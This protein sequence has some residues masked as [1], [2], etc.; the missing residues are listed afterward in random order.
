MMTIA[1]VE[2][3][4]VESLR[5]EADALR[6]ELARLEAA[7]TAAREGV[8]RA[9]ANRAAIEGR[10]AATSAALD[11]LAAEL[12]AVRGAAVAGEDRR[13][14]LAELNGRRR[15]LEA[16]RDELAEQ[17]AVARRAAETAAGA[18]N[19]AIRAKAGVEHR[20]AA[21]EG[22]IAAGE[23]DAELDAALGALFAAINRRDQLDA[24]EV[25]RAREARDFD[26]A[27]GEALVINLRRLPA[28]RL[29]HRPL[30]LETIAE[31]PWEVSR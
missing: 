14:D 26:P 15:D 3:I 19:D 27:L 4:A 30:L 1:D 23:S 22:A 8:V 16:D 18:E 24:A 9:V 20:L 21:A 29:R 12:A 13:A 28:M 25:A 10:Q 11:E 6:D 5:D 2:P 7:A 31:S 17:F